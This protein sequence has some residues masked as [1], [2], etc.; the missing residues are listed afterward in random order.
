MPLH[1]ENERVRIHKVVASSI[2][3]NA[4][5]V[6]CKATGESVI[7]DAPEQA[8]KVLDEASGTR[9][10]AV[11]IT[12]R[13]GDHTAGY[14]RLKEATK[15]AS[16]IGSDDAEG[17]PGQPDFYLMD[18]DIIPVGHLAIRAIHTPGHTPGATCLLLEDH[19]FSGDTLFPGGPGH[20][21]TPEAL[22]QSI[23]SITTKLYALPDV[24]RVYPGHGDGTTIG[25]SKREYAVFASKPHPPDLCGDVLWEKS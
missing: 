4:Y 11:L 5:V 1:F 16:A 12:H 17:L 18:G 19:L 2:A 13:H 15:A 25:Q 7:V 10:R 8:E 21:R 23:Q 14:H 3:N 9:V 24:T 6:V 20:T 22:R